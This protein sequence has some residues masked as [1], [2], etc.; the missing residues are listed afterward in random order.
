MSSTSQ[1]TH[2][3]N[4]AIVA[5][6]AIY[7]LRMLGFFMVLPV[8]SLYAYD[9]E[10]STLLLV[11]LAFGIYGLTQALLQIP[12]GF[13][14]DRFGRKPIITI[15]LLLLIIGSIIAANSESITMMIIGRALQGTGAIG[16]A[17][18]ALLAD[19]THVQKRTKAMAIIG[20]FISLAFVLAMGGGALLGSWVGLSGIFW[21]TAIL[22]AIAIGL[23]YTLVPNPPVSGTYQAGGFKAALGHIEL[24][25]LN[26]G[27]FIQ[28]MIF[29]A[30]FFALPI[31]LRQVL[32]L[33]TQYHWRLYL[34][35]MLI[36]FVCIWP[37]IT[38]S[39]K[40][41]KTKMVFLAAIAVVILSLMML[42]FLYSSLI[43]LAISFL[44]YFIGFNYLEA[45]LPSLVSKY[46]TQSNR[47]SAL[48]IYSSCQF[49]GIFA[50]GAIAGWIAAYQSIAWIFIFCAIMATTWLCIAL[51]MR[52]PK[53]IEIQSSRYQ[54]AALK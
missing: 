10:G 11:G 3:E 13:C 31:I 6:A 47:G 53:Q 43:W 2:G 52:A 16:S 35:V 20:L 1:P 49:L 45:N 41:H 50:G 14:S 8:F 12:L 19:V 51:V 25:R 30:C 7:A 38:L 18:T 37:M 29:S 21:F 44:L 22:A 32:Q 26:I 4:Q 27:I 39:E 42:G 9:L 24:W 48:G 46:S 5:I 33:P 15:G 40:Y 34:P 36:S 23:L 28:H 17:L 54:K